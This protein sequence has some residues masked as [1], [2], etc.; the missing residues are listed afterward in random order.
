[1]AKEFNKKYMHPTRRKLVDMV[2]TG[3]Y[4]KNTHFSLS[5]VKKPEIKREVG[6]VW[7]DEQG[8]MWEQRSYGKIK[9]SKITD[10]MAE[11]REYLS[12]LNRCKSDDCDKKGKFGP[13]DKKLI[14]KTGF[15]SGCLAKKEAEIVYDGLWKEYETWKITS[16]M[17]AYGIEVIE[18]LKQAYSDAKQEYEYL[19]E[20]GTT[21]KWTMERPVEELKQE[22]LD[23]IEKYQKELDGVI[24]ANKEA[25]DKLKDRNYELVKAI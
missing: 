12:Q 16:N 4:D 10:T 6:D 25:Y 17:I 24:S 21:E 20:N 2:L 15:C 8:N 11:V 19:N 5:D 7:E 14:R 13:T 1:M 23:D 3:E 18:N 22:I 9:K